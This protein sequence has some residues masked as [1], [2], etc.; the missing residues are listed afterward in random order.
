MKHIAIVLSIFIFAAFLGKTSSKSTYKMKVCA[1]VIYDYK[2]VNPDC[3]VDP[4][5]GERYY[6]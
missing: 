2:G 3:S 5:D 6:P 4:V 1:D